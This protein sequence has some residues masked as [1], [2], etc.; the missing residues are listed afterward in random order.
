MA[1]DTMLY[2]TGSLIADF[3]L[4]AALSGFSI[5]ETDIVHE[6][7][8][9]PHEPPTLP[10]GKCAVYVF[11]L[12]A[13]SQAEG[14]KPEPLVLKVGR[15][16]P[17]TKARFE[18]QHY[19]VHRAPS[20]LAKSLLNAK[21]KWVSLGIESLNEENVGEWIKVNTDRDHFFLD[22]SQ[23][24]ILSHL[25]TFLHGRLQPVFEGRATKRSR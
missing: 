22:A 23:E 12:T 15:A 5:R 2:D 6:S 1:Y 7:L 25:E 11:S 10:S 24:Q 9:G 14:A 19:G 20:T 8:V 18:H 21:D 13:W 16:G 17:N 4:V 3:I